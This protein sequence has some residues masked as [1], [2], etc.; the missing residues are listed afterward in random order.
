MTLEELSAYL[1]GYALDHDAVQDTLI[2]YLTWQGPPIHSP[3]AW[4]W[5]R[6]KWRTLDQHRKAQVRD[7]PIGPSVN[8]LTPERYLL[9]RDR[10]ARMAALESQRPRWGY[11]NDVKALL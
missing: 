7:A 4:A 5:R 11:C 3:K 1:R 2:D 10:L 9:A 8:Q 6:V